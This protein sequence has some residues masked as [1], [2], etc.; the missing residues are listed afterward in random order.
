MNGKNLVENKMADAHWF[1]ECH[2]ARRQDRGHHAGVW[3]AGHQG[4]LLDPVRP[5]TDAAL[6]LGVTKP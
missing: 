6:W 3:R 4:R 5:A 1:I 2:G